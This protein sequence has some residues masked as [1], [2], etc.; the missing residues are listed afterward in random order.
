MKFSNVLLGLGLAAIL[1]F[2]SFLRENQIFDL[3]SSFVNPF[4]SEILLEAEK[5]VLGKRFED[6]FTDSGGFVRLYENAKVDFTNQ[7]R[8]ILFGQVFFAGG[9][10]EYINVGNIRLDISKSSV[11]IDFAPFEQKLEIFSIMGNVP[12]F[13][14]GEEVFLLPSKNYVSISLNAGKALLPENV[15]YNTYHSKRKLWNLSSWEEHKRNS[16]FISLY[17]GYLAWAKKFEN[18]ADKSIKSWSRGTA[19]NILDYIVRSYQHT[20]IYYSLGFPDEKRAHYEFG[21]MINPIFDAQVFLKNGDTNSAYQSFLSFKETL[22]Q[23]GWS[24]LLQRNKDLNIQWNLFSRASKIWTASA[25]PREVSRFFSF[26]WEDRFDGSQNITKLYETV[27]NI[28][29]FATNNRNNAY[30]EF[31]KL[32]EFFGTEE[33]EAVDIESIDFETISFEEWEKLRQKIFQNGDGGDANSSKESSL[34]EKKDLPLL[35]KS[36]RILTYLLLS[37]NFFQKTEPYKIYEKIVQEELKLL[38][39]EN[40]VEQRIE[41]A[42]DVFLLIRHF[43]E[44]ASDKKI[45][46]TLLRLWKWVNVEAIEQ[47]LQMNFFTPEE[48]ELIQFVNIGGTSALT[49]EEILKIKES[50]RLE[51]EIEEKIEELKS[52]NEKLEKEFGQVSEQEVIEN[53]KQLLDFLASV[54]VIIDLQ[55][56]KTDSE[57]GL[58]VFS[59]ARFGDDSIDGKFEYESQRFISFS[60]N[61]TENYENVHMN[62]IPKIFTKIETL[63]KKQAEELAIKLAEEARQ[64]EEQAEIEEFSKVDTDILQNTSKAILARRFIYNKMSRDYGIMTNRENI[65]VLD[66]DLENYEVVLANMMNFSS[67]RF[68]YSKT[69]ELFSDIKGKYTVEE[70]SGDIEKGIL[71]REQSIEK[72]SFSGPYTWMEFSTNLQERINLLEA[73]PESVSEEPEADDVETEEKDEE[74]PKTESV[75]SL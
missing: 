39:E 47:E 64:K 25:S 41:M 35:I 22:R 50:E 62:F 56:F 26:L 63:R 69:D 43:I 71:G 32:G 36:R 9:V 73:V 52:E 60:L 30:E 6:F 55:N 7:Q 5:S 1:F 51:R 14:D 44:T 12:I 27:Q 10:S 34:F 72:I 46:E 42:N 48:K 53:P 40:E 70:I 31:L 33:E 8:K 65:F 18:F 11:F 58:S 13:L 24:I 17:K 66:D 37:N 2:A 67:V 15:S 16:Q 28:T 49:E 59:K 20:Q 21:N 61:K 29:Y 38:D 45:S 68:K 23:T 57:K 19:K 75:E 74:T 3:K 4:E 54:G